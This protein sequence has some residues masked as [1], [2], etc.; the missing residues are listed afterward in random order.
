MFRGSVKCTR[1]PTPFASFSFFVPPMRHRVPSQF[2]WTVTDAP[3]KDDIDHLN[4]PTLL[5]LMIQFSAIHLG[6]WKL[7]LVDPRPNLLR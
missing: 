3:Q 1:L 6:P 5:G 2:N 7:R 4:K